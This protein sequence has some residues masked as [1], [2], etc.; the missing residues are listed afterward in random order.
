MAVTRSP[1]MCWSCYVSV[2]SPYFFYTYFNVCFDTSVTSLLNFVGGHR[3]S[4][5]AVKDKTGRLHVFKFKD[6][7]EKSQ[8]L[9]AVQPLCRKLQAKDTD[10]K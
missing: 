1:F 3:S 8:W 9:T 7:E 5:F 2:S 10:K 4:K 6:D